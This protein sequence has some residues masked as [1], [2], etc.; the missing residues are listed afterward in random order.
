MR[1]TVDGMKKGANSTGKV[2]HIQILKRAV[3]NLYWGRYRWS[4][5]RA[6]ARF[7]MYTEQR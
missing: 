4:S 7:Y 3:G 6:T 2:M 5:Y 1:L